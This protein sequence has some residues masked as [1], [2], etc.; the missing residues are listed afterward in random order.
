M[1]FTI[2]CIYLCIFNCDSFSLFLCTSFLLSWLS[3]DVLKQV[4][5]N[6]C[7]I[8]FLLNSCTIRNR[9]PNPFESRLFYF[10]W[11]KYLRTIR[12]VAAFVV[13]MVAAN[14]HHDYDNVSLRCPFIYIIQAYPH[15]DT[16]EHLLSTGSSRF[17]Y[18]FLEW[19]ESQTQAHSIDRMFM[20]RDQ[21]D[22]ECVLIS[23][24]AAGRLSRVLVL[25]GSLSGI[26][27]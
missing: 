22:H 27:E 23:A 25:G 8:F 13:A 4:Q 21:R 18:I 12:S 19:K 20:S 14:V 9:L 24:V 15:A 6:T 2:N 5:P 26:V 17:L 11:R 1:I 10:S 3:A 16:L 7:S